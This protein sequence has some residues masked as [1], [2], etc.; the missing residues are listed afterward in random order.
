MQIRAAQP[1]DASDLVPLFAAWEHP[2]PADV[3]AGRLA[4]WRETPRAEVLVAEIEGA[5][6]GVA[7][8][9]AS[10]HFARPGRFG[11][12]IGLAVGTGFRRRGV[13]AALL[14]AA[15]ELA[16][17]WGC[18]RLELTT[19]RW[20]DEAPAFYAAVGYQD[21]SERQARFMRSL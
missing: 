12:L 6:A 3:I 8:V 7:A 9:T 10:P 2:Q 1:D 14:R 19:S 11:R 5:V 15:E 16:R 20:R 17:S 21:Q 13:G 4:E 18:D